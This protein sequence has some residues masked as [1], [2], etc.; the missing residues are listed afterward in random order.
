MAAQASETMASQV[1]ETQTVRQCGPEDK[2]PYT[3][4]AK[5]EEEDHKTTHKQLK[6]LLADVDVNSKAVQ[7]RHYCVKEREY[8]GAEDEDDEEHEDEDDEETLEFGPPLELQPI[9]TIDAD[10]LVPTPT[11]ASSSGSR[12]PNAK[13]SKNYKR[14]R[15]DETAD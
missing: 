4:E 7:E 9:Q 14:K 5:I 10:Q 6:L 12:V 13:K 3:E 8:D 11:G 1:G 2:P 15:G